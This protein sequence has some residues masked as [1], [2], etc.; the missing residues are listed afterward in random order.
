MNGNEKA[1]SQ[2]IIF[3]QKSAQHESDS[4]VLQDLMPSSAEDWDSDSDHLPYTLPS[5]H[6]PYTLP[7]RKSAQHD[8]DSENLRDLVPSSSDEEEGSTSKKS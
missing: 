6:L 7:T 2:E 4:D 8:S 1:S 5:D 3:R